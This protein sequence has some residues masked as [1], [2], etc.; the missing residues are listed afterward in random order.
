MSA[1]LHHE[2]WVFSLGFF[3]FASDL[4]AVCLD[5]LMLSVW[6]QGHSCARCSGWFLQLVDSFQKCTLIWINSTFVD[7]L[8]FF[9]LQSFSIFD[10]LN[11]GV[12]IYDFCNFLRF[13]FYE[14]IITEDVVDLIFVY[15]LLMNFQ[16]LLLDFPW[17]W[18]S[19]TMDSVMSER[20]ITWYDFFFYCWANICLN[21]LLSFQVLYKLFILIVFSDCWFGT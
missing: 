18:E 15:H 19:R 2:K 6:S 14:L 16:D 9:G 20:N 8:K 7:I 11:I 3:N 4:V 12:F 13:H 1:V 21:F 17:C 10:F 5:W